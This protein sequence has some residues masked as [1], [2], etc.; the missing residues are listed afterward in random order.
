M[1]GSSLPGVCAGVEMFEYE[2]PSAEEALVEGSFL[3]LGA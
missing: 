2:E 3:R 1:D